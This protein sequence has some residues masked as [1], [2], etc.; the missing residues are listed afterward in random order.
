VRKYSLA[1]ALLVLCLLL[2]P[3]IALA[4]EA[5]GGDGAE[6]LPPAGL[7]AVSS[8][9][10]PSSIARALG[11][12]SLATTPPVFV[13]VAGG[14]RIATAI[15]ASK[16]AFPGKADTIVLCTG[17]NWP[18]A[19]G[20][21]ALAGASI[22]PL[23]LTKPD[24]L[25]SAV[26]TEAVRLDAHAVVVIGSENAV[27]A[28]VEDA[29]K[30][31]DVNGHA[32]T[33][34]RLA[35]PR[36]FETSAVV[37]SAVVDAVRAHGG[38]YDGTA[39]FATSRNFPD[40]LAAS[41]IAAKKGWPVLLVE[42]GE[43]TTPTEGAIQQLGIK[44]GIVLGSEKAVTKV[45]ADKLTALLPSPPQRL[46]GDDRYLTGIQI[47]L[48]G[49]ANGLE[50]DGVGITTG[51]NFPDA[52]AG[53]VM[54]GRLGSV[55]LLTPSSYLAYSVFTELTS[56]RAGIH[57]VRYLGDVSAVRQYTRDGVTAA[58]NGQAYPTR[59]GMTFPVDGACS[60]ENDFG[61][62]R[63]GGRTHEG[64]DILAARG[65]PVVATLNGMVTAKTNTLGG[66]VIYLDADNGW[67]FYYAHLNGWAVTSGHVQAGQKIGYVG[68]TGNA[69]GGPT[70]LHFQMWTPSGQLVN[71]YSYLKNMVR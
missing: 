43:L 9:A 3:A 48:F 61:A 2:S 31:L 28:E 24:A 49:V 6:A 18:D 62:P 38:T 65:V 51:E 56:L 29:L 46:G 22:G 30:A 54:Q 26:V 63:S 53:G 10:A 71:P 40:A 41:P 17:S 14:D 15:A 39:F 8:A 23:L 4:T 70:H 32:L 36:R 12:R 7:A 52:L 5:T 42:P 50:W 57:T 64:I 47:A 68:N 13:S 1:T 67:R 55:V 11:Y 66:N 25:P 27:S 16:L 19:L 58:L 20:G 44:R 60:Y 33:V 37:A 59:N 35:G 69:A 21:A 34:T 45:A